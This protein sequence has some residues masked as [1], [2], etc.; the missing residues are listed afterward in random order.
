MF[1]DK[2]NFND[3]REKDKELLRSI[4]MNK[5]RI[6]NAF[7]VHQKEIN[8]FSFKPVPVFMKY[9]YTSDFLR[10]QQ[11][12]AYLE[13]LLAEYFDRIELRENSKVMHELREISKKLDKVDL[14]F[15]APKG[16]GVL[17]LKSLVSVEGKDAE[18]TVIVDL[19]TNWG[20]NVNLSNLQDGLNK[21]VYH[22][23]IETEKTYN[24]MLVEFPDDELK[25]KYYKEKI[26]TLNELKDNP[27]LRD[28]CAEVYK[29]LKYLTIKQALA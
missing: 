23:M 18:N 28:M 11:Q 16:D 12:V 26:N 27:N 13:E 2:V 17:N 22:G 19:L 10:L 24:I 1:I 14:Q 20:A 5:V 25:Q 3:L 8:D 7:A 29:E 21:D 15:T 9:K 6:K 4:E